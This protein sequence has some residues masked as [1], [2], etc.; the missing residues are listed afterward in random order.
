MAQSIEGDRRRSGQ[1]GKSLC[2]CQSPHDNDN[3]VIHDPECSAI[4]ELDSSESSEESSEE[5]IVKCSTEPEVV[6]PAM[7]LE[8]R[9]EEMRRRNEALL[10]RFKEVEEDRRRAERR[11]AALLP[12]STKLVKTSSAH[13][14]DVSDQWESLTITVMNQKDTRLVARRSNGGRRQPKSR[15]LEDRLEKRCGEE[16]HILEERQLIIC[17]IDNGEDAGDY[18][19]DHSGSTSDVERREYLRW[20]RRNRSIVELLDQDNLAVH[21]QSSKEQMELV[22]QDDLA[23]HLQSSKEQMDLLDQDDLAVHLQSSREQMELLDQDDL[24]VHLQSSRKQRKKAR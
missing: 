2:Q 13:T 18:C 12:K 7:E 5:D 3:V 24:A 9:I 21:L 11:G 4:L 8:R 10:K 19:T 6:G 20:K 16:K 14:T 17:T 22:D 15:R 1:T 23:V